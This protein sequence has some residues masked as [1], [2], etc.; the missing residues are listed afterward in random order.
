MNPID[1]RDP[2]PGSKKPDATPKKVWDPPMLTYCGNLAEIVRGGGG[3]LSPLGGDPG[4]S[5]K[6]R[7]S[8]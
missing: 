3:K 8:G 6:Q 5:R 7:S 1:Q 4:D 2:L